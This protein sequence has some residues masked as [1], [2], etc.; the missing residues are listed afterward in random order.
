MARS[1]VVRVLGLALYGWCSHY[2]QISASNLTQNFVTFRN[3]VTLGS[4]LSISRFAVQARP[5]GHVH[6]QMFWFL[7]H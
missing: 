1:S 5:A 3:H 2:T 7:H 4:I 6:V